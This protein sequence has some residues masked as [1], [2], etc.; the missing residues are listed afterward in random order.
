MAPANTPLMIA[1]ALLLISLFY[2]FGNGPIHND[3]AL[4]TPHKHDHSSHVSHSHMNVDN[5]S[6]D[7]H[8]DY[9]S[10]SYDSSLSSHNSEGSVNP[11]HAHHDDSVDSSVEKIALRSMGLNNLHHKRR[12]GGKYHHVSYRTKKDSLRGVDTDYYKVHDVTKNHTD[13]YSPVDEADPS[14]APITLGD[15]K[16]TEKDKYNINSFLPQE[17][18]KDWFETI[19]TVDVK[20]SHLINIYRPIG[21]NT[22]GSTQKNATYDIRGTDK[23]VCPKYVVSPW[24]QSSIEPDRSM[25]SLC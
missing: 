19:E 1:L 7:S 8:S 23:A 16:D 12:S 14:L 20:N 6:D 5:D 15:R 4:Q 22:I 13:K 2:L 25:K 3:G 11:N 9:S 10:G 17:E 24:L 18:E 21:V